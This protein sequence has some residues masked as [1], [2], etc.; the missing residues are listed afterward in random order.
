LINLNE[1]KLKVIKKY[2][3]E[4]IIKERIPYGRRE[5]RLNSYDIREIT[6]ESA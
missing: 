5:L 3:K 1:E 6:E 4:C 2:H